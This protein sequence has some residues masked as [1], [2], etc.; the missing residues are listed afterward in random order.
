MAEFNLDPNRTSVNEMVGIYNELK[1]KAG[2][3]ETPSGN[4]KQSRSMFHG[5]P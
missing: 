3:K 1:E 4:G 5:A 2:N